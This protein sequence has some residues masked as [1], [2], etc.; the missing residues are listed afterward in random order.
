MGLQI[1]TSTPTLLLRSALQQIGIASAVH[2]ERSSDDAARSG[3]RNTTKLGARQ[4]RRSSLQANLQAKRQAQDAVA[5]QRMSLDGLSSLSSVL[6][7]MR[8][9]TIQAQDD[10]LSSADRDSIDVEFQGLKEEIDRIAQ[11]KYDGVTVLGDRTSTELQVGGPEEE[12]VHLPVLDLRSVRLGFATDS[13]STTQEARL[14]MEHLDRAIRILPRFAS[15]RS[16]LES[17]LQWILNQ[18]EQRQEQESRANF[19]IR[20]ADHALELAGRARSELVLG[21]GKGILA[22]A[23]LEAELAES[24]L[25]S[26]TSFSVHGVREG[27]PAWAPRAQREAG[28]G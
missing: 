4:R 1:H 9:L 7:R 23:N 14:A 15:T 24:L 22:Q 8:E 27:A 26:G 11:L 28:V 18:L 6:A 5:L 16:A 2:A 17:R 25:F 13:L 12:P 3:D 19:E 20:D 10:G 21:S